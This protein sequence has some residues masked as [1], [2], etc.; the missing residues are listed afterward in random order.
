M[1][2]S[3]ISASQLAVLALLTAPTVASASI[4]ASTG[5]IG[6]PVLTLDGTGLNGGAVA[7][8]SG[9]TTYG[10]SIPAAADPPGTIGN[11]LAA[12]PSSGTPSTL[13]FVSPTLNYLSFLWGSPDLYNVLD[14]ITNSNDYTYTALG[15]G[16]TPPDGNQAFA[17]DVQFK[18]TGGE[19]ITA[20]KFT[21]NTDA[22]EVSNFRVGAV[23]EA[24][25]WA[26]MILGFFGVGFMA[27]RR[28]SP[29]AFRLA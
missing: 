18:T 24:S 7:T 2:M 23:P 8:L 10:A 9:G 13:N 6:G 11:F 26:M 19:F 17:E 22:F 25:T 16:V 21:S 4:V 15:M 14:V 20:V 28:K 27:Y 1:R 29:S 5:T 3:L 12:G